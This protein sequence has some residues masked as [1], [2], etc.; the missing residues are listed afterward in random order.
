MLQ[1]ILFYAKCTLLLLVL[2]IADQNSL[3]TPA[4]QSGPA[5]SLPPFVI[6]GIEASPGA[7]PWQAQLSVPG[8]AHWCGGALIEAQWVVTAAHCVYGQAASD[9]TVVLGEHDRASDEGTEQA[10]G[11]HQVIVHPNYNPR[12]LDSDIALLQLDDPALLNQR[13]A[14]L[15][16]LDIVRDGDLAAPGVAATVTGWGWT[17]PGGEASNVLMQAELPIAENAA[18]DQEFSTD[19]TDNMLCAGFPQGERSGCHGDSGG[20]LVV[21]DGQGGWRQAGIVSWERGIIVARIQ[22]SPGLRTSLSGCIVTR[23]QPGHWCQS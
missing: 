22:C 3:T 11:V 6:G 19:L 18:C 4:A 12:T 17:A 1:Q 21:S 13:V 7:W 2:L 5:P 8:Y 15:P 23:S 20:P 14:K 10:K 16:L 9:V